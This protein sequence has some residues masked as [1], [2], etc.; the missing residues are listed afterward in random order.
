MVE[1][2]SATLSMNCQNTPLCF[3]GHT[4]L[5]LAFIRDSQI[6][7]GTYSK[8]KLEPGKKY[9]VNPGSVGQPPD[10]N[11]NAAYVVYDLEAKSIELRRVPYDIDITRRKIKDAGL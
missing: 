7:G 1:R 4:H 8:F 5:P 3:F 10:H 11:P 2:L 6:K 9:F